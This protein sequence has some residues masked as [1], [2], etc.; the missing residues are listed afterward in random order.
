[1]RIVNFH[2]LYKLAIQ[3]GNTHSVTKEKFSAIIER[4]RAMSTVTI[5]C[6]GCENIDSANYPPISFGGK[7]SKSSSAWRIYM[8]RGWLSSS[9]A[10]VALL[11]G[12]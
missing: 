7:R 8:R 3:H 6:G 10:T 5:V 11:I 2:P 9:A 12:V 1:V 4:H